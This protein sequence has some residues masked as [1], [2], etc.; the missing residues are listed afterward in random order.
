VWRFLFI[1]IAQSFVTILVAVCLI[2]LS[3]RFLP[4]NPVLVRFGQHP[5]PAKI[6]AEMAKQGWDKPMVVQLGKFLIELSQ[7]DLG[8]SFERPGERITA[9]LA[10]RVP[11]TIELTFCALLFAVPLGLLTGVAAAVWHTRWPD[12][13]AMTL[14]MLGVSVPVFFL[15]FLL[16]NIFSNMPTGQRLPA[17][18]VLDFRTDFYLF[19]SILTGNFSMAG[20][21]LKH[22]CLPALALSSIPAAMISRI[23]R[24]SMLEVLSADYL[25]TARAKGATFLHVVWR[26][27]L[28]NA[29]IPITNILGYQIGM[30][31]TG[32]VLTE[33]IFSWPGMGSYLF[34]A[35]EQRDY[36]IVQGGALVIATM[37]VFSNLL[38]DLCFL[39]LDPRLRVE[40]IS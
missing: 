1:R 25:R 19:E 33:T 11:A 3:I 40:Q 38:L 8:E 32:A 2:F 10:E 35:I 15:G 22:I 6:E 5:V 17:W 9:Q 28:P 13:T 34:A 24:S 21:A 27:A 29:A 37:F 23:T 14:A 36:A 7:G 18:L 12:Y 30:L 26:H 16:M 4:G 39:W 31:L 20:L